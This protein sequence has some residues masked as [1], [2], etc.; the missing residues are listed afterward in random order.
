MPIADVIEIILNSSESDLCQITQDHK[1]A[2][3]LKKIIRVPMVLI[4]WTA[5]ILCAANTLFT[6]SATE[7]L[8]VMVNDVE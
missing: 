7:I 2:K 5:G 4:S 6:K 3:T 1:L 8:K